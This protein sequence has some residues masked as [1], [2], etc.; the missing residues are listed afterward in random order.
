MFPMEP[1]IPAPPLTY[2]FIRLFENQSEIS[3]LGI[4]PIS[5]VEEMVKD[6][7]D[8][9]D[10]ECKFYESAEDVHD[11]RELSSQKKNLMVSDDL[12]LDHLSLLSLNT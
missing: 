8:K 2:F 6:I 3:D 12:L 4:F 5:I 10:V 9:S 11:P 1:K 7:R